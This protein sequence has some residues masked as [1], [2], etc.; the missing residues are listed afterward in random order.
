[1]G[2]KRTDETGNGQE[3]G[4]K[5]NQVILAYDFRKNEALKGR[6]LHISAAVADDY[7]TSGKEAEV[8]LPDNEGGRMTGSLSLEKE[9]SSNQP[10]TVMTLIES[11]GNQMI[12]DESEI[13]KYDE[14]GEV[15]E[16]FMDYDRV[17]LFRV[18]LEK[19][20]E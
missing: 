18:M 16:Y 20:G 4:S 1:M 8:V 6:I 12:Y 11:R 2:G 13:V 3:D 15:P 14:T 5:K 7:G 10:L 9:I 19:G 17:F